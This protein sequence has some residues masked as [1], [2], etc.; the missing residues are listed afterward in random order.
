MSDSLQARGLL[1]VF[2][3]GNL[4]GMIRRPA[5]A[6]ERNQT[7]L[8]RARRRRLQLSALGLG[9]S[10]L[11]LLAC[12]AGE[13]A[14][15][16]PAFGSS[17]SAF[18]S[19]SPNGT[20]TNTANGAGTNNTGNSAGSSNSG[21]Q[22]G[23]NN[24]GTAPV[25]NPSSANSNTRP[26]TPAGNAAEGNP[27]NP[28]IN[29]G[30]NTSTNG[31]MAA[32]AGGAGNGGTGMPSNAP[33]NPTT[34]PVTTPPPV[35]TTPPPN[36]P[37]PATPPP[38]AV[39]TPPAAPDIACPAGATFC[40]GFESDVLPTGASY[41]SQPAVPLAFD[42]TVKHSGT[43]SLKVVSAGGFNIR[44]VVAPI[45]GQSFWVRLFVQTSTVFGDN[46]HD[47]LFVASTATPAQDNNAEDG[48]EF[49]EQGNQIILNASDNL[50]SAAGPGFPQGVGP[51][52]TANTFHCEEAFYDGGTG[53]VT[54]FSD[55]QQILD[56][57]GFKPLSYKTFR[58][59]Y[60]GFNTVRTVW[61]D[62]VVVAPNRVGCQ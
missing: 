15:G 35:T 58:F 59:G 6:Q 50:F 39:P 55:G 2:E 9:L 8:S 42:T 54:L 26:S 23:S 3:S 17:P 45:P 5:Q 44:E 14:D 20:S 56:A 46:N 21:A 41:Q 11:A 16:P 52:L 40:S 47:S 31:A 34:P 53:D 22:N 51:Q 57:P 7:Q 37:P 48:P 30:T 36:T 33:P 12:G 38:P 29:S 18:P 43:R 60:I 24:T 49:S 19:S 32:G 28:P 10:T 25:S 27:S 62:D 61:Y 4:I 13:E 1:R